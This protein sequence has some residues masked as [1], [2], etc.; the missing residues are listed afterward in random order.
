[1]LDN[2]NTVIDKVFKKKMGVFGGTF[3]PIHL[4]HVQPL[5]QAA[6]L[7][8]IESIALLPCHI[9][10]HKKAT[11][12]NAQQRKDMV[13]IICQKNKL[14][15]LDVRE[16]EKITTSYTIDTLKEISSISPQIQL[17]FFIG[18]DSLIN[19]TTWYQ[20][21]EILNYCHLVVLPRPGY[22]N[23]AIPSLL[24]SNIHYFSDNTINNNDV[25]LKQT[26]GRIIIMPAQINDISST[27]IRNNIAE[28]KPYQHWLD[29][30]VNAYIEKYQLY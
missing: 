7:L 29:N 10:P 16:L 22:S 21:Q 11:R 25:Y 27:Q 20:W 14:F 23:K 18:M 12:A 17:Y 26:Y 3:D 19:F 28:K 24:K 5:E 30:D 4:G 6:Q 2:N 13:S 1:M 8:N 15:T 9:P